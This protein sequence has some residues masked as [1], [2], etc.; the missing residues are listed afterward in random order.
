MRRVAWEWRKLFGLPALW[1]F[2]GLCL[3]LN[4]LLLAGPSAQD[5]G[6][7]HDTSADA[8]TLGQRV[9][10][11]F[12]AG[13]DALPHTEHRDILRQSVEGLENTLA[14][15]DTGELTRF[16]QNLMEGD[17]LAQSWMAW[18]YDLLQERVDHL[19]QTGAAL[20]VYAG[21]ITHDSHYYLY[22]T[23]F[24]VLVAE[25][26]LLGLLCAIYLV[27]YEDMAGTQTLICA[28]CTG[29]RLWRD[30]VVAALAAALGLY[31]LLAL[32]T[33]GPYL[34][35]W[36]YRGIWW[37]SVSSQFNYFTDMLFSRPFLTWADFTVG[38][39]FV[40]MVV[41]GAGLV[42]VFTLMGAVAGLLIGHT[43]GAA[44]AVAVVCALLLGLGFGLADLGLWWV[45]LLINVS[46]VHLW[47]AI[48]GWFTELGQ[49]GIV[50]W[51]ETVVLGF[52][53]LAG[54]GLT[55]L[56]LRRFGRKDVA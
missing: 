32:L 27:G 28:S 25:G 23:L 2:V 47:L 39:Y 36:D 29:R 53:L 9:D 18:K 13:L 31:A 1:V 54:G 51:Q 14:S 15:Y 30:K 17:P 48:H 44:I 8:A 43:Y 16:Y 19:A 12:L 38:S 35:L 49:S 40:A 5:R 50:P 4:G 37:A 46:P 26:A 55:L 11:E 7:F 34:M 56:A 22:N 10:E 3:I 41:A 52:N 33:L 20:D 21:P 6:F 45:Y 42:L 24:R